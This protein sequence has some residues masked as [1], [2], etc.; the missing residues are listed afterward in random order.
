LERTKWETLA[1]D[2]N[3]LSTNIPGVFAGGDFVSG[4]G[5]VIEAIAAGRRGALAINKYLSG[6]SSRVEMYDLKSETIPERKAA[7]TEETW[8]NQPRQKVPVISTEERKNNFNEIE[9][10]FT[11]DQA[12]YEAKRC[13]RC[14]LE[15]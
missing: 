7:E 6:D 11:E 3:N 13:L 14:D 2:S 1:V 12:V 9:I 10:G 4:P 5:M 15:K 8:Q